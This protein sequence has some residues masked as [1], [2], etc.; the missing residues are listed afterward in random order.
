MTIETITL[1]FS[2]VL[3]TGE[4]QTLIV[5]FDGE[6]ASMS[7]DAWTQGIV[8][9]P[10]IIDIADTCIATARLTMTAIREGVR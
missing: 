10:D 3:D 1:E 6:T 2:Q 7:T 4:E 8:T 9:L 5:E